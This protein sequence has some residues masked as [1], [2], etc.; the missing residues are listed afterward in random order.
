MAMAVENCVYKIGQHGPNLVELGVIKSTNC[1]ISSSPAFHPMYCS[2]PP[3]PCC[4]RLPTLES[5]LLFS[6]CQLPSSPAFRH[7]LAACASHCRVRYPRALFPPDLFLHFP[8]CPHRLRLLPTTSISSFSTSHSISSAASHHLPCARA[9]HL[10]SPVSVSTLVILIAFSTSHQC[11][12]ALPPH[13]SS[14][15]FPRNSLKWDFGSERKGVTRLLTMVVVRRGSKV[16]D[17]HSCR[18]C[19]ERPA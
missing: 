7:P 16:A 17:A 1:S 13:L 9:S 6:S 4:L 12:A 8:P 3:S 5:D 2:I 19:S 15:F 18:C 14:F 10:S 11:P